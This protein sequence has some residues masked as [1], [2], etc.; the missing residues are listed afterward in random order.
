MNIKRQAPHSL[1]DVMCDMIHVAVC[2]KYQ[3]D[4]EGMTMLIRSGQKFKCC[5]SGFPF[6]VVDQGLKTRDQHHK[7]FICSSKNIVGVYQV[8]FLLLHRL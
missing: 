3:H 1:P 7:Y 5:Y 2:C 6:E 8:P 4:K